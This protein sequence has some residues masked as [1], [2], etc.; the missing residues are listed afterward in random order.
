MRKGSEIG[1]G[2][3]IECNIPLKYSDAFERGE[4]HH[5]KKISCSPN[6][7]WKA[8][9]DSSLSAR[10]GFFSC[11]IISPV[12][13][14]ESGLVEVV[15]MLDLLAEVGAVTNMSCGLHVHVGTDGMTQAEIDRMIVMFRKFEPAFYDL[16]GDGAAQRYGSTYCAPSATWRGNRYQS[17]NLQ[18][19][20]RDHCEIRVWH[21]ALAP[22]VVLAAIYMAVSLVS[23]ST[24]PST[25]KISGLN[26]QNPRA[27]MASYIRNFMTE[28]TMIV[29]DMAPADVFKVMMEESMVTSRPM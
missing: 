1:F 7:N 16:N 14:G 17:L 4:Y 24:D 8:E 3:E 25:V 18:N 20:N 22:E 6:G 9:K 12:L 13:F 21:S 5:G 2:I 28:D 15:Q 26:M 23:R 19:L 27:I 29:P 11:E 10:P